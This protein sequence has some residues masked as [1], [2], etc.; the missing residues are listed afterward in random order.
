MN[1]YD[2]TALLGVIEALEKPGR[3]LLDTYF[4]DEQVFDTEEIYWDKVGRARRLA[5]FVSPVVEGKAMR[6][7][8]FTTRSVAPGYVKPK[9]PVEP[10]KALKRRAGERLGGG[11]FTPDQRFQFA[12][13]DNLA[14][15]DE[16][17]ARREEW[18]ASQI[19]Q[20]GAVIIESE[21]FP[22]QEVD[23]GRDAALT[24]ALTS[25]ARWGETGVSPLAY[26]RAKAALIASKSGAMA[27][28]VTFDPLAAEIFLKDAEVREILDNRR[29]AS[30]VLELS[31]LNGGMT[32]EEAVYLGSIGQ[33][34]FYQY[35]DI[36][37]TAA[38]VEQKMIPDYSLI[39]GSPG[40]A[41][42]V[43]TYGAIQDKKA[44]LKAMARF[45]KVWDVEDPPLTMT[46]TQSAPLP[47]MGRP[48]AVFFATVR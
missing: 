47:V 2:T 36:Y 24:D 12:V 5:P 33:F 25:T 45:P 38:G 27:K 15:E 35:Q 19:L 18:M 6:G 44:G 31:G 17:I 7:R 23:F 39:L 8:G 20:T 32:P 30:G 46:M 43:R 26:L 22:T 13:A 48:D 3:F 4:P 42:G 29:Q 14:L 37:E 10:A 1:L 21:D 9:H 16:Q 41:A 34:D 11:D 28:H 40:Q